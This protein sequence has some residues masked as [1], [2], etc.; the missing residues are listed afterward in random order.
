M[1]FSR[2]LDRRDSL[3]ARRPPSAV[4]G[5]GSQAVFR[6]G[7]DHGW[8]SLGSVLDVYHITATAE[9]AAMRRPVILHTP[10]THSAA[11]RSEPANHH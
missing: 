1:G 4:F 3:D 2:G 10:L 8:G 9:L 5:Q 7:Q 11:N 6:A